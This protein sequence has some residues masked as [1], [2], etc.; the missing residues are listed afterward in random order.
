MKMKMKNNIFYKTFI[1]L[2]AISFIYAYP[3]IFSD[4][5]YIDDLGRS[6]LGYTRWG[7][8]G[9]PLADILMTLISFGYP[10]IDISPLPQLLSLIFI[11]AS[12]S[13][14]A[15]VNFDSLNK[16]KLVLVSLLFVCNPFLIENLSYKYD[17]LPMMIS[18]GVLFLC[19]SIPNKYFSFALSILF[20]ISSLSLYQASISIFVCLSIIEFIKEYIIHGIKINKCIL[21]QIARFFQLSISYIT[22]SLLI[23]RNYVAG[24]YNKSHSE[25]I[26]NSDNYIEMLSSNMVKYYG[27]I[28]SFYIGIPSVFIFIFSLSFCFSVFHFFYQQRNKTSNL[29]SIARTVILTASSFLV[30]IASFLHLCLLREPVFSPR[31][32]IGFGVFIMFIG[33]IISSNRLGIMS[34]ALFVFSSMILSYSYGNSMKSQLE[35]DRYIATSINIDISQLNNDIKY[36]SVI[37]KMPSAK[38]LEL[39]KIRFPIISSLVPIYINNNWGWAGMLLSHYGGNYEFKIMSRHER[40]EYCEL[41]PSIKNNN[42]YLY[43]K[44]NVVVIDFN[45][46]LCE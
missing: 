24:D 12:V 15:V 11:C 10:L 46:K 23:A 14:Y 20:I 42:Y 44:G 7:N 9:R 3:I 39:S 40:N 38:Q 28:K 31:V 30:L 18:A 37:G 5:F 33:I 4:R 19:F 34:M 22:Y 21:N 32:M 27:W 45:K 13:L 29:N 16:K 35:I 8:N 2:L 41:K 1:T 6:L 36:I 25:L 26:F 43:T 17:S